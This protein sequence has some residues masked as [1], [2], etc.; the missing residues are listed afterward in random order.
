LLPTRGWHLVVASDTSLSPFG[1]SYPFQKLQIRA[2]RW[3]ELPWHH[4][5]RL[6]LFGGA[7]G[8]NAPV[9]EKFYIADFSDLLPDRVLD[10][11]IDRRPAP[12]FFHTAIAELRQGD[13][14][15]RVQGEYRIPLYRGSRSVYGIDFF[16]AAGLYSVAT[17]REFTDPA[18]GYSGLARAPID[19]TFN[20]G[21]RVD[22]KAG[23]FVIAFANALGFAPA[24]RGSR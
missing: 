14:A 6:E 22:S 17:R 18:T 1:S 4:V 10:L 8:G 12:N 3:W 9:F 15:A 11:N 5:A 23:G 2:S 16:S 7:I 19:F 20:L 13:Y 21:L 24:L